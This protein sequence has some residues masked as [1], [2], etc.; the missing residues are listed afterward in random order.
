MSV[1][2]LPAPDG[3]PVASAP[4]ASSE[5]PLPVFTAS[6]AEQFKFVTLREAARYAS[7]TPRTVAG[8]LAGHSAEPVGAL[9]TPH[10]GKPEMLYPISAVAACVAAARKR[11]QAPALRSGAGGPVRRIG[12]S[13]PTAGRRYQWRDPQRATGAPTGPVPDPAS[14]ASK[15]NPHQTVNRRAAR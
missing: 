9:D 4:A 5:A 11:G 15:I 6:Q 10:K 7:A 2:P 8:W 1:Q 14:A 13:S 12:M 3:P